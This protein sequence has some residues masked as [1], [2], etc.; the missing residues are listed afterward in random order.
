MGGSSGGGGSSGAVSWPAYMQAVHHQWLNRGD[1]DQITKSITST[2]NEAF[3]MSPFNDYILKSVED[4]FGTATYAVYELF[5]KFVDLDIPAFYRK[6]VDGVVTSEIKDALMKSTL[7]LYEED[8]QMTVL[9]RFQ[10]GMRDVNAA[11]S[12]AFLVG[13]S[14]MES[15]RAKHIAKLSA[16]VNFKLLDIATEVFKTAV[17]WNKTIVTQNT[18]ISRIFLAGLLDERKFNA[19]T[20][21][22][23]HL[24]DL[25]VW[26]YGAHVMSSISGGTA[27]QNG[28]ESS[29][30]QNVLGGAMSGAAMGAQIGSYT[31]NAGIGAGIG[32]LLGGIGGLF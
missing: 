4:T 13:M 2:M 15:S 7:D 16:D 25:R 12:S 31:G 18:E 9:P 21:A 32:G 26:E 14:L 28:E 27:A 17:D 6:V 3:G 11:L 1:Q 23:D 8:Y 29:T 19:E 20:D 5:D 10:S 30:V 24:W 22:K